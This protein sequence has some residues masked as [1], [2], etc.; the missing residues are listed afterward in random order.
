MNGPVLL[1]VGAVVLIGLAVIVYRS[2]KGPKLPAP[3]PFDAVSPSRPPA[4]PDSVGEPVAAVAS[5]AA[6]SDSGRSEQ[7]EEDAEP[8]EDMTIAAYVAQAEEQEKDAD[9]DQAIDSISEAIALAQVE[10]GGDSVEVAQ[11][12][13]RQGQLF[14][15]RDYEEAAD[16]ID[17]A[18]YLQALAILQQHFGGKSEELLPVLKLLISWYYQTGD[19][20]KADTLIRRCGDISEA[21]YEAKSF[22][23][24]AAPAAAAAKKVSPFKVPFTSSDSAAVESCKEGDEAFA[25]G[26]YDDAVTAFEAAIESVQVE[27]GRAAPELAQLFHRLG[28]VLQVKDAG[29]TDDEGNAYTDPADNMQI[30]LSMLVKIHGFDAVEIAPLLLD[31]AAFEDQ[32]GDHYKAE[33]YLRR[34]DMLE[35]MARNAEKA[36][37]AKQ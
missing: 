26:E 4:F 30:A 37:K 9:F 8:E 27:V 21:A 15:L 19:L 33:T 23:D 18:E 16:E 32:R 35:R 2:L 7:Q 5:T 10:F 22:A 17:C 28:R 31:L 14:Q 11:L 6:D 1:L 29:D 3:N 25:A 20:Q 34:L 12:L 13:I 36:R 24:Q